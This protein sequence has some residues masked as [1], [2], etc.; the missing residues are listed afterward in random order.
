MQ[1]ER[2][3]LESCGLGPTPATW[4]AAVLL[5]ELLVERGDVEGRRLDVLRGNAAASE[6]LITAM[7]QRRGRSA[8]EWLRRGA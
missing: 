5:A 8:A 4:Y 6:V 2:G 3:D 7:D 1:D